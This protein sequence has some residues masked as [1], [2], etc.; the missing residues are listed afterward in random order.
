MTWRKWLVRGL[1]FSALGGTGLLALVYQAW[2]NPSAIRRQVL[3]KLGDKFIGA[4]VSIESAQLRLLGGIAVSDLRMSRRDD[5]DHGDFLYAP[6]AVIYHDKEQL[7]EGH[8]AIRKVEMNRPR[9]R[10]VR[11]PDNKLNLEGVLGPINLN[12]RVPV[13]VLRQATIVVEDRDGPTPGNLLEIRDVNLTIVNDP[14]P[15]LTVEGNGQTDLGSPLQVLARFHRTNGEAAASLEATAIPVGPMLF[16]RLALV[17]P[18]MAAQARNLTGVGRVKATLVKRGGANGVPFSYD[19]QAEL[20]NG[21][22]VDSRLPMSLEKIEASGHIQDGHIPQARLTARSGNTSL[23]LAIR[24]G[25]LP[26]KESGCLDE[27]FKEIDL[28]IEHL[29]VNPALFAC[30][31]PDFR[32]LQ[33]EY[34][35]TGSLTITHSLRHEGSSTWRKHWSFQLEGMSSEFAKFPYPIE[36]IT[37]TIEREATSDNSHTM[38][39]NLAGQ[40]GGKPIRLLGRLEGEKSHEGVEIDVWGD[41]LAIDDTLLN[42]LPVK[43]RA[44]AGQFGLRGRVDAK[45]QIRR[46]RGK[47]TYANRYFLRFHDAAVTYNLFPYPI[48]KVTGVLDIHPDHWECRDFQGTN[49]GGE[50][51]VWAR[52]TATVAGSGDVHRVLKPSEKNQRIQVKIQGNNIELDEEFDAA[53]APR[54]S[55]RAPLQKA[56]RMM[57]LTGKLSFAAEVVDLPNQ[58]QN[59]DVGVVVRGCAM[60]PR[61]FPYPLEDVSASVRYARERVWITNF[62]AQHNASKVSLREG[63]VLLK[64]GGGFQARLAGIAGEPLIPDIEFLKSLPPLL[65]AGIE[66]LKLRDPVSFRTDLVVDVSPE[67]AIPPLIWWDGTATL[68]NAHLHAGVDLTGLEGELACCGRYNG[69]NLEGVT[70]NILLQRAT[71]VNQPLTNLHGRIEVLPDSPH[72]LRVKDIQAECF[73]G[74]VGGEARVEFSPLLR[75]DLALKAVQIRLEE[76]ARHNM[77]STVDVEGSTMAGLHL[78]GEGPGVSGLKGN[79]QISIP[80]GKLYRLPLL[81]D[82]LKTL[83]LRAPDRTAFEQANVIFSFD[84]PQVQVQ[85]LDLFGNVVSLRGQGTL[86]L[87]GSNL[88]LDFHADWARVMQVLPDGLNEL[89]R[90]V[91]D[92]LFKIKVRGRT[93]EARIEKELV[94]ALSEP[95]KRALG[96]D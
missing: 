27:M 35:P 5:L 20:H 82:M 93:G 86:N 12:E 94:P 31:P 49:K 22:L 47:K 51:R 21:A 68:H 81:L 64:P 40:A 19:V 72:V 17:A 71:V 73:G 60:K 38:T 23:D 69:R 78:F 33:G 44:L 16:Q 96:R 76:F 6:T 57:A 39:L 91:S 25:T 34:K 15:M 55:N 26:G 77:P 29:P 59:I 43:H 90:A 63:Q 61:F 8:L 56:W 10:V 79:G 4:V 67:P 50:I 42:S 36:N 87:D 58:P 66:P 2:T 37:G 70:G 3:D 32:D 85:Q 54:D 83:G 74:V 1:V 52:S 9:I 62:K 65:R 84:G 88:N 45:A 89:P 80:K 14:L 28:H 95:L 92:Q 48:E 41:D 11:L 75:Y 7:L 13:I 30:L 46:E 24:D 18:R 53:L